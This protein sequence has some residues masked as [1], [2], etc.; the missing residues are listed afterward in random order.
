MQKGTWNSN[1]GF[2]ETQK[3]RPSK[4]FIH[5][6]IRSCNDFT[7]QGPKVIWT[8]VDTVNLLKHICFLLGIICLGDKQEFQVSFRQFSQSL[9]RTTNGAVEKGTKNGDGSVHCIRHRCRKDHQTNTLTPQTLVPSFPVA[10]KSSP[11]LC[12]QLQISQFCNIQNTIRIQTIK[13]GKPGSM[14]TRSKI[15][16]APDRF[17]LPYPVDSILC[18]PLH[19]WIPPRVHQENLDK[20]NTNFIYA[21]N[22]IYNDVSESPDPP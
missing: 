17:V 22:W 16:S 19:S 5:R 10:S 7:S 6:C 2:T 8:V 9:C 18:L 14:I 1:T 15:W 13:G 3:V 20:S 11:Q 21:W 12:S 4:I